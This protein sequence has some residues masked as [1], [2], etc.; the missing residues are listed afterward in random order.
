LLGLTFDGGRL[1]GVWLKRT[2][3]S[4]T[5][6]R[7]F[8]VLLT[9]D[10]LTAAPEL[11]GREIRNQLD[12]AGIRERMCVIGLPLK[13]ALTTR[14]EAPALE[15]AD[16]ESFLQIEAER[17]FPCD[18]ATLQICTSKIPEASG[19]SHALLVG[20]P[21]SHIV[22]LQQVLAA[23]RLHPLNF[24]IALMALQPPS[25]SAPQG[26]LALVVGETGVSLQVSAGGGV[27]ALRTIEGAIETEGAK[28]SLLPAVVA[29]EV[30]ITLGQLPEDIR[31][32]ITTI[33]VF[34]PRELA[35]ALT[36]ELELRFEH[37][38][39][40]AELVARFTPGQFGL[41]VPAD[42]P[43]SGALSLAASRLAGRLPDFDFLPPHV[44]LL[45]QVT[46]KYSTGKLRTAIAIAIAAVLLI[47]SLFLY[48]QVQ[49]LRL[50]S[51]WNGIAAKVKELEGVQAQ[52]RQFR[53][54]Y[55]ENSRVMTILKDLTAAFPEDGV[56][57]AKTVEI[58]EA[59][60]IT[61]T[62]V[63]RDN[64]SLLRTLDRLQAGMHVSDLKVSQIRGRSPMQFTFDFRWNEGSKNER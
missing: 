41:Q 14:V 39:L 40:K 26:V 10:P 30:R 12:A 50:N 18:M 3:G 32:A 59:G 36:D 64:A 23:A 2:N 31:A 49:L 11:V 38:G 45:R 27:A 52:I 53:P 4:V 34:G 58:R 29:R 48:Q 9:L 46:Q 1:E 15:P 28:R 55:D 6:Q 22:T 20:I 8:S 16:A 47:G 13:W 63:A 44:S 17:G 5:V 25:A 35:Q 57:S 61:C 42:A 51:Q 19:K 60:A 62:G 21:R 7:A 54:W 37:A 43:V 33:R 56:V 24:S